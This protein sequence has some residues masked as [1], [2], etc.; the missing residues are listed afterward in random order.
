MFITTAAV[1]RSRDEL[2]ARWIDY[3]Y[4][5]DCCYLTSFGEENVDWVWSDEG[6][7]VFTDY[8]RNHPD[9]SSAY[10][11]TKLNGYASVIYLWWGKFDTTSD[12]VMEA[13][14]TW[15][16]SSDAAYNI[17]L[18]GISLTVEES[19]KFSSPYADIDTYVQEN[20]PMIDLYVNGPLGAV[21]NRLQG[22]VP[23][24][25]GCLNNIQTWTLAN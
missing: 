5:L 3:N 24:M 18:Y 23:S 14:H 6:V 4:T 19:E 21:S 25:Y 10:G 17:P 12:K 15:Q 11:A 1:E 2:A 20:V 13:Y 16:D 7:P 8:Y 9:G 22:A